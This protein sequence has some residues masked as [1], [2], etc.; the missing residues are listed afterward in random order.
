M[1]RKEMCKEGKKNGLGN[2]WVTS[3]DGLIK[4]S[5]F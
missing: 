1:D 2:D 3:K 4:L 5:Y